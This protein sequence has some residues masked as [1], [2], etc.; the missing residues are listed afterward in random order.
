VTAIGANRLDGVV[1]QIA[2]VDLLPHTLLQRSM[3]TQ[4]NPLPTGSAMVGVALKPGQLPATGL[5][6]G[7]H[8]DV[9]Q[10]PDHNATPT[11]SAAAP[12]LLAGS[13][14]VYTTVDDASQTGGTLAT[15]VVPRAAAAGI[16]AASDAG[17][18]ALV[19]V[20]P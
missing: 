14:L 20:A 8:V 4:T 18:I 3:L 1:G 16:A 10:L 11:T 13:A 9:L 2:T 17:S 12:R 19:E 5:P 6:D 15:L 7:A